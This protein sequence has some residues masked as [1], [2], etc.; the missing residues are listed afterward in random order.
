M[1]DTML[2]YERRVKLLKELILDCDP[3]VGIRAIGIQRSL[4][5][6]IENKEISQEEFNEHEAELDGLMH[7]FAYDCHC[8]KKVY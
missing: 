1:T 3:Q 7:S 8:R 6:A 4:D 5:R 2:N